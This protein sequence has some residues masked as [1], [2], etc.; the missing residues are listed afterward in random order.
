MY[1]DLKKIRKELKISQLKL[2]ERLGFAQSYISRVESGSPASDAFTDKIKFVFKIDLSKYE[3]DLKQ[4]FDC[5][6]ELYKIYKL[7]H[8]QQERIEK[9]EK[10]QGEN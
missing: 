10:R 6:K 8:D 9:L 7:L 5:E 4:G 2:S 1:L 3:I